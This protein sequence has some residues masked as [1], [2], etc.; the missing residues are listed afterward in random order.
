[1][2]RPTAATTIQRPDL[3]ALAY[4][5]M[6]EASRRGF[7]GLNVMPVFPVPEQS[8]DFPI[9]PVESLLKIPDMKRAPRSGYAR[10]DWKFT[11]GTYKCAQY[12]W[13]EPMDDVE[14]ALYE[15]F[16]DAEAVS[17]EI[18]T[19]HLI[20]GHEKRVAAKLFNTGNAIGNA[21]AAVLWSTPA[22]ATPKADIKAAK[23]ALRLASGVNANAVVMSKSTFDNLMVTAEL[24]TYMQYTTPHLLLGYDAQ[25]QT[26][27]RYFEVDHVLVADAMEDTAKLGQA[28]SLGDIWRNDYVSVSRIATSPNLKEPAFGRTFLWTRMSPGILQAKTYREEKRDSTIYRVDHHTDEAIQF[29]GANYIITGV[30]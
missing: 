25:K 22:T 8:S 26:V 17:M 14:A 24:K 4:E 27:A 1:M 18:A 3:G 16:F 23:T 12:G 15:R 30:A 9:I 5:Y 6:L 13:E 2:P 11:M 28:A 21:A 19:D 10:G 7:I 29:I 20:R